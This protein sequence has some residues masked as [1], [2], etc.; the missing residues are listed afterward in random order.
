MKIEN[1]SSYDDLAWF[2]SDLPDMDEE[3]YV[4]TFVGWPNEHLIIGDPLRVPW[5]SSAQ[6]NGGRPIVNCLPHQVRE[7]QRSFSKR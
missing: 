5:E 4:L 3:T 7:A 2:C 1:I 6:S